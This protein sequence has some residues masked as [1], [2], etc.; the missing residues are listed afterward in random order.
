MLTNLI[1]QGEWC[2]IEIQQG[3]K[4]SVLLN[5]IPIIDNIDAASMQGGSIRISVDDAVLSFRRIYTKD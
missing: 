2:T 4:T 3:E 5:G 1:D